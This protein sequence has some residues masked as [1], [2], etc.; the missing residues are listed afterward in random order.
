MTGSGTLTISTEQ[1]DDEA[2]I[3]V[4][5]T[6]IGMAEAVRRRVFEP[7][8][9]TKPMQSGRGLGLSVTLGL[10]ESHGGRI[11]VDSAPGA[12]TSV[13][14]RLPMRAPPGPSAAT[15]ADAS[16]DGA[17]AGESHVTPRALAPRTNTMSLAPLHV[18]VP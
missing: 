18:L 12:G 5:D 17:A 11:R 14:V 1:Q 9:T 13:E 15:T 2:V 3:T 16:R 7:F 8:F 6:G 10:V 4:T